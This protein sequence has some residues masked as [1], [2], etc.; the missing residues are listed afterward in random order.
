MSDKRDRVTAIEFYHRAID[1][2]PDYEAA[3]MNLGNLY[4]EEN[5]LDLAETYLRRSIGIL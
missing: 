2:Y 4:R 5:K 1:L 3:I